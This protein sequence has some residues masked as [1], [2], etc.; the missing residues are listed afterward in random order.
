MEEFPVI[1]DGSRDAK[2]GGDFCGGSEV[3]V[4]DGSEAHA[5]NT[6]GDVSGVD[7]ANPANTDKGHIE[8]DG[9]HRVAGN[10][11]PAALRAA[12][13]PVT[14]RRRAEM[15]ACFNWD[16]LRLTEPRAGVAQICN[17]LYRRLAVGRAGEG[18]LAWKFGSTLA[19]GRACRLQTCDTAD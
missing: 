2:L 9:S 10:G 19:N 3:D 18:R 1:C 15:D 16:A 17:P 5:W 6:G 11:R 12:A 13:R 8:R 7:A 14:L 4:R